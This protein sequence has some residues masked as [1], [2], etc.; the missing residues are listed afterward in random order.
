MFDLLTDKLNSAFRGLTGRGVLNESNIN[1]ALREVRRALLEADVN[2]QVVK[3]FISEVKQ[4]CL[5]EKVLKSL[6]PGEQAIKVVHD[7]LVTLLGEENAP[8]SL[9]GTP[10]VV[11]LVGL[12]GGGKTTSAAKLA[13]RLRERDGKS[14]KMAA[15]DLHRP[16]AIDQL[17]ILGKQLGVDVYSRRD[18]TDIARVASEA[19]DAA[20][21]D[22]TEVLLVDTAGRHQIDEDLIQELVE[23]RRR[24]QP[25]EILL[26]ADSALGQEAVSVARH[27]DDALGITG[28]ILSKLDGDARG[29]AALSMRQVTGRPIKFIGIGEGMDKLEPFHPDRLA[30]RI[31][32]MGDVVGLV[33]KASEQFAEEEAEKLEEKMR[34]QSFDFEDFQGQ[35]RKLKK[36]GGL[37]SM[38]DLLPGVGKLKDKLPTDDRQLNR[39]DAI[40]G[41]MT[42]DER[43]SPQ[44]LDSSRR[45]RIARGSGV[46]TKEVNEL[47]NRFEMLKKMM[48]NAGGMGNMEQML[49]GMEGGG[50][51]PGMPGGGKM[52]SSDGFPGAGPAQ[53]GTKGTKKKKKK[54]KKK[55]R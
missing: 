51:M 2:Y 18:T 13:K 44:L 7:H 32:G 35:L 54:R 26:V 39:I 27:F 14:V 28:L 23:T 17:E 46:E 12:H 40:I 31:L 50:S 52:P 19:R 24:V 55:K 53:H 16:A 9:S 25:C 36:M 1:D 37:M 47:I 49:S 15:C 10:A 48:G 29:G 33:E 30:S 4:E 41:S 34:K 20:L 22:G 6:K 21:A 8:L 43:H 11:M 45:R 5:G 42:P 3:D 38:L